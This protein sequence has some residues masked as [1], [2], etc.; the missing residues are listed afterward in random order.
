MPAVDLALVEE[1]GVEPAGPETTAGGTAVEFLSRAG[2]PGCT[3]FSA[4]QGEIEDMPS[5]PVKTRGMVF[6]LF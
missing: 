4:T 6:I 1:I 5:K 3:V 2:D